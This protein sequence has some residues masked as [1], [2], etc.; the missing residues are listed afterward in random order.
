MLGVHPCAYEQWVTE[1]DHDVDN[2]VYSYTDDSYPIDMGRRFGPFVAGSLPINPIRELHVSQ[3]MPSDMPP[4]H[5]TEMMDRYHAMVS[6]NHFY[7]E[8]YE[9][10]MDLL[11]EEDDFVIDEI[12]LW[13]T[14]RDTSA[15]GVMLFL[16]LVAACLLVWAAFISTCCSMRYD[17]G[18]D[19]GVE[20]C[21]RETLPN[22]VVNHVSSR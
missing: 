8:M 13:D 7:D 11:L 17:N 3:P 5:D 16:V 14:L 15:W 19:N 1:D 2:Y 22:S 18:V 10:P 6:T 21:L 9:Q 4:M 20:R 12:S